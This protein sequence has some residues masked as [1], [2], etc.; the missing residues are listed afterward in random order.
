MN[1]LDALKLALPLVASLLSAGAAGWII[2]FRRTFASRDDLAGVKQEIDT[3]VAGHEVR[4]AIVEQQ[5]KAF[6]EG[7]KL[8]E[9]V[10]LLSER[11][12]RTEAELES[13]SVK[14]STVAGLINDLL[15][16]LAKQTIER[17]GK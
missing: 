16:Q 10:H 9:D 17:I 11:L 8:L 7:A 3:T 14:L 1:W 13:V 12:A 6:P 2:A 5:V 15:Q 4:I